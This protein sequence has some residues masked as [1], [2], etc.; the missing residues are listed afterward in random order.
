MTFRCNAKIG[1]DKE[2]RRFIDSLIDEG[3]IPV[4][5]GKEVYIQMSGEV[6]LESKVVLMLYDELDN[7]ELNEFTFTITT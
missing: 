1:D 5:K 3:I 6:E 2:K 4:V 7:K